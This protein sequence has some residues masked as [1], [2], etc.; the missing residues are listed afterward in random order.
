MKELEEFSE[1]AECIISEA[2]K[3]TPGAELKYTRN[4]KCNKLCDGIWGNLSVTG[5]GQSPGISTSGNPTPNFTRAGQ[6][7]QTLGTEV[8]GNPFLYSVCYCSVS[9]FWRHCCSG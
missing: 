1:A 9:H 7:L 6:V 5:R 2:S 8:V 4:E 3:V